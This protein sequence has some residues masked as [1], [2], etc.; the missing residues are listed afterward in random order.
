MSL[1]ARKRRHARTRST[2]EF[3]LARQIFFGVLAFIGVSLLITFIWYG[4][5]IESVTITT[6]KVLG[7]ETISHDEVRNI[8]ERELTGS[9]LHIVPHR[10]AYLYPKERIRKAVDRLPRAY[11]VFVERTTTSITVTFKEY[12]PHALWCLSMKEDSSCYLLT[13]SGYAF[14]PAPPLTGGSLV[15]YI[16]E[17]ID[18]LREGDVLEASFVTAINTLSTRL[19]NTL[20][21][22]TNAVVRSA[23]GDI[24][25]MISGGGILRLPAQFDSEIVFERLEALL[26]STEFRHLKPGNF[27]YIDLRFGTK[28]FVNE[29]FGSSTTTIEKDTPSAT[30]STDRLQL[31]QLYKAHPRG[32]LY[33][34]IKL[35]ALS[36]LSHP[37]ACPSIVT[38]KS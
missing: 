5:R 20:G 26:N 29:E 3:S 11:D 9:Y 38:L 1:F 24:D 19:E 32:A 10:F 35:S 28:I 36:R 37:L 18:E 25:L 34:N 4:T 13:D 31:M 17:G 23:Y 2:A 21:I 30:S 14:A 16:I 7:G 27:N 22:R 12:V 33:S 15:R 6:I 8:V